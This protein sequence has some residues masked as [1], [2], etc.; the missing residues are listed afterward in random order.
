MRVI[1]FTHLITTGGRPHTP[2]AFC[3]VTGA[4]PQTNGIS[5]CSIQ[6]HPHTFRPQ[7]LQKKMRE[8]EK[9]I[10]QKI[11]TSLLRAPQTMPRKK[12]GDADATGTADVR[13]VFTTTTPLRDITNTTSSAQRVFSPLP[14]TAPA[15]RGLKFG[16][17]QGPERAGGGAAGRT[18]VTQRST[19]PSSEVGDDVLYSGTCALYICAHL[20]ASDHFLCVCRRRRRRV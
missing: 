8:L 1:G 20:G 9:Q 18:R 16:Q 3:W 11:F 12:K 7:K 4:P 6:H 15:S 19:S 13:T 5:T 10:N 2:G 17:I 14:Q